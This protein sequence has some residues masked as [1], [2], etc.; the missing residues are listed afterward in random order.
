MGAPLYVKGDE[1]SPS[2]AETGGHETLLHS[3]SRL[4]KYSKSAKWK[5]LKCTG[6]SPGMQDAN[7]STEE[8]ISSMP[9]CVINESGRRKTEQE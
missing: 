9:N 3:H 5:A 2:C 8:S 6:K 7:R 1:A 4:H